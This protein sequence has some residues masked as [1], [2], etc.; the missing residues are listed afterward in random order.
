MQTGGV[1]EMA[2]D[3]VFDPGKTCKPKPR[4]YISGPMD[5]VDGYKSIFWAFEE[6][7]VRSG[8]YVVVDPAS[9][10]VE[11]SRDR[12][13][14]DREDWLEIDLKTLE[15]CDAIFMMP[16]WRKS[17]GAR[18]EYA[19]AKFLELDIHGFDLNEEEEEE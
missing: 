6:A 8:K 19:R 16:G 17:E 12:D 10:K 9:F 4:I 5:G 3:L 18:M 7:I 2:G 13:L 11:D 1:V 14:L 15:K